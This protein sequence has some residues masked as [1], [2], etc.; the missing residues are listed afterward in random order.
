MMKIGKKINFMQ[1]SRMQIINFNIKFKD[2]NL[3]F[4]TKFL[5][6]FLVVDGSKLNFYQNNL[7]PHSFKVVKAFAEFGFESLQW[8]NIDLQI[9]GLWW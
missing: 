5:C 9:L 4:L 8:R 6:I 3:N 1:K 7:N 2:S